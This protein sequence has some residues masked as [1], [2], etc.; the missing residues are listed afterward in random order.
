MKKRNVRVLVAMIVGLWAGAADA[1]PDSKDLLIKFANATTA[2]HFT[3]QARTGGAKIENLGA[4]NWIRVQLTQKQLQSLS[5]EEIRSNPNV[6]A[7]QPNYK[8]KL[9]TD[10]R[11]KNLAS[12]IQ[13]ATKARL[14]EARG[15]KTSG[16][17]TM[18]TDNPEIPKLGS[19]G[20][21]AD[22]D[23]AKQ[24][25]MN[26]I[27]A[28]NSWSHGKG[29][30][31]VVAVIDTGVDYTHEDLVDNLWRNS[32][33]TGTDN[34]GRDKSTNGIDDDGNGFVDDVIGWDFVSDDN[35]PFDLALEPMD[36]LMK[37]GNPGH[38][39]HCAGNVAA[40]ANNGKGIAGAAPEAQ[41]MVLRFLS[42]YGEGTTAGAIQ[43][44]NYAV[45]MGAKVLSNSWGSEG[46]DPEEAVENQALRDAVTEAQ[47]AGVLFIAAAGNGHQGEGYDNDTDPDPTYPASYDHDNIISVA[48]LD[49]K[50][51]LGSFS[52]WGARTVDLGAPG[53]S[54]YSTMVGG[55]YSDKVIDF[56]GIVVDWDGTSMA[57]PHAAGAAA[58]YWSKHPS[59]TWREVKAALLNSAKPIGSLTGKTVSG[60]K[61][62][63]ESLMKR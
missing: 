28:K 11:V 43:S 60:G 15:T 48:A 8:V 30:G 5:V 9:L 26:D 7:V 46:E 35:K 3:L 61:L 34:Q 4:G 10:Y 38:G 47:N 37:G 2:N 32:G 42:E 6:L 51:E 16:R 36:I 1:T 49:S 27:G 54:V 23:L 56:M 21:G 41:I 14:M 52:N 62:N 44:I 17:L 25:G 13:L 19:G 18:P 57:A 20:S 63:S 40:R 22:P 50:D 55:T 12:R 24:W 39:T 58:A 29:Q 59:A 53:V 31:V 33:E 45:S